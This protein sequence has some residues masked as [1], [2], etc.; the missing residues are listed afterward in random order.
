[1]TDNLNSIN[2][3]EEFEISYCSIYPEELELR[4]EN[5]GK[6]V[7]SILDLDIKIWDAN[8]KVGLLDKRDSFSFS[9]VSI[10]DG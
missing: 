1:M 7:A 2:D 8:V 4:K 6:H 5:T 3:G 10:S 9:V